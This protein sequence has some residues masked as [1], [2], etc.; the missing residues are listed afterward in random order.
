MVHS[1]DI[2]CRKGGNI[3][4]DPIIKINHGRGGQLE[5]FLQKSSGNAFL[6]L[7]WNF[8]MGIKDT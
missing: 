8:H 2:T 4:M 5:Y 1:D 3:E 6:K 7:F